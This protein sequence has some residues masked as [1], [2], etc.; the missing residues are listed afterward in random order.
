MTVRI[1]SLSLLRGFLGLHGGEI[2]GEGIVIE[3]PPA[4]SSAEPPLL[5]CGVKGDW[6]KSFGVVAA[7]SCSFPRKRHA[8][9]DHPPSHK[10]QH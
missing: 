10:S 7:A 5:R 6:L 1:F 8:P 3:R 4:G 2:G 9:A